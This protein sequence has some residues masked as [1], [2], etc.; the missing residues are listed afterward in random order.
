MRGLVRGCG[1]ISGLEGWF[2]MD[3]GGSFPGPGWLVMVT[4]E[5]GGM[6]RAIMPMAVCVCCVDY[7]V[8]W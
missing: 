4:C 2:G 6:I 7:R 5:P 8:G 3:A 1:P